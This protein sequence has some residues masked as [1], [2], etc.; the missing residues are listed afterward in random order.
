M[1]RIISLVLVLLF[2]FSAP[3]LAQIND[4]N[5]RPDNIDKIE[6]DRPI[7]EFALAGG[8]LV[9]VLAIGFMPSKRVQ[10]ANN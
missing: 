8:F 9:A 3:A 6:S 10:A 4:E 7:T 2:A 5:V 1:R